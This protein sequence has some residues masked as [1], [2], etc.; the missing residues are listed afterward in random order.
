MALCSIASA[1]LASKEYISVKPL[2]RRGWPFEF[3][4][5]DRA[6]SETVARITFG[7]QV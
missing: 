2:I 3:L 7:L 5:C 1:D 6:H 4:I